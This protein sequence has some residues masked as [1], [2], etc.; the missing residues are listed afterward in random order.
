ML[1]FGCTVIEIAL[2]LKENFSVE[3]PVDHP[4]VTLNHVLM[5]TPSVVMMVMMVLTVVMAMMI[6]MKGTYFKSS[7]IFYIVKSGY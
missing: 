2:C 3:G 5:M 7:S 4:M 6:I 1:S